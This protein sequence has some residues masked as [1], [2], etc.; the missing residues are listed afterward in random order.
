MKRD[1]QQLQFNHHCGL[2]IISLNFACQDF[3][4]R[5]KLCAVIKFRAKLK[6]AQLANSPLMSLHMIVSRDILKLWEYKLSSGCDNQAFH[7]IVKLS[8]PHHSF[9]GI[10]LVAT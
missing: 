7:D 1:S 9:E 3:N 5:L 2:F 4:V 10:V 8:R 6:A